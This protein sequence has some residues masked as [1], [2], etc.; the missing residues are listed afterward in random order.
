M[1]QISRTTSDR[2]PPG[3]PWRLA[4]GLDGGR[5]RDPEDLAA[6]PRRLG[7]HPA[8]LGQREV[9]GDR[10]AQA[11]AAGVTGSGA[12]DFV[13]ALVDAG[14]VFRRDA[15]AVVPDGHAQLP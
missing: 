2:R 10:E 8:A 3:G 5:H 15:R 14:P 6:V 7:P 12:V 11:R 1:L 13:E 9:L 4:G